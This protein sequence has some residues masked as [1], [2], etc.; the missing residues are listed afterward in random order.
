MK[1]IFRIIGAGMALAVAA[2][3][4]ALAQQEPIIAVDITTIAVDAATG[5]VISVALTSGGSGYINPPQVTVSGDGFGAE[6][7]AKV[8]GGVVTALTITKGGSGYT[9]RPTISI[10][11]PPVTPASVSAQ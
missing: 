3:G 1:T 8:T 6:V 10:A 5:S 4:G 9:T 11:P 7:V 2:P